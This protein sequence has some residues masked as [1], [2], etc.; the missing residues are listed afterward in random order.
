MHIILITP[1]P[2]P[3]VSDTHS[4]TR[5]ICHSNIKIFQFLEEYYRQCFIHFYLTCFHL[6]KNRFNCPQ[7]QALRVLCLVSLCFCRLSFWFHF[8]FNVSNADFMFSIFT[9]QR[10]WQKM[11]KVEVVIWFRLGT[12]W[13][14]KYRYCT[15]KICR[16]PF[17][18]NYF[19]FLPLDFK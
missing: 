15:Y 11:R 6:L 17:C 16:E 3:S 2:S 18:Y 13:Y 10:H 12:F 1:S 14:L 8:D 19:N 4:Y 5:S 9:C 7:F